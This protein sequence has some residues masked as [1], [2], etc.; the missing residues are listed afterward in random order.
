[1]DVPAVIEAFAQVK[2]ALEKTSVRWSI[3]LFIEACIT[4]V[5]AIEPV[6]YSLARSNT[7]R[8]AA[9]R[10]AEIAT[11]EAGVFFAATVRSLYPFSW[12]R[13]WIPTDQP[14]RAYNCR[15]TCSELRAQLISVDA[16]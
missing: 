16:S 4:V 14:H 13:S 8:A 6:L 12:L 10:S 9:S 1:M 11:A 3:V 7:K 15:P 5:I 2:D